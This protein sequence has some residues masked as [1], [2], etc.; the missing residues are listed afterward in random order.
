MNELIELR[1]LLCEQIEWYQEY[2]NAK[3]IKQEHDLTDRFPSIDMQLFLM[4]ME[5]LDWE[6]EDE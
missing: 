6:D 2:K 1:E 5:I 4:T 3:T